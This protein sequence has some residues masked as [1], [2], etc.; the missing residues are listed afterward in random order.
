MKKGFT[1]AEVIITL[2]IIAIVAAMTLPSLIGNYQKKQTATQLKKIYS[3]LQ[4]AQKRAEVDYEAIEYWD[5]TLS[6]TEF[7]NRY[8]KPYYKILTDYDNTN[9]PTDYITNCNNGGNCDGYGS[10]PTASK[11]ILTD[12]TLFAVN[13]AHSAPGENQLFITIIVDINGLKK[14]NK[15]GRDIFMFSV[16]PANGVLPYGVGNLAGL[17][18]T[19]SYD[20][21]LLLNRESRSCQKDGIFCAALIM[22]DNWEI[23]DDYPW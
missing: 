1:L 13:P 17:T 10:F 6:K 22:T 16:Q 3:L 2:G 20:R 18:Q 5:F 23:K 14:P 21:Q 4:Q 7:A 12:G 19:A 15:Y 9:F 11:F 8:I